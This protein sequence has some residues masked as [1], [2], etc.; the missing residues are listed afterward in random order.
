MEI[1][2]MVLIVIGLTT[3]VLMALADVIVALDKGESLGPPP[4]SLPTERRPFPSE[5]E[6][7]ERVAA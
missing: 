1:I 5:R 4:A 2:E 3:I 6:T 7:T